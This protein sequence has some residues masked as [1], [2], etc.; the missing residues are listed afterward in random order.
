MWLCR[1]VK[2]EKDHVP[3]HTY[4]VNGRK[5]WGLDKTD[6]NLSAAERYMDGYE[7]N[8]SHTEILG[9][10]LLKQARRLPDV[11]EITGKNGA[12]PEDSA[13][14]AKWGM[15]GNF[16]REQGLPIGGPDRIT[17]CE[18]DRY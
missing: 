13:F 17:V 4:L 7:G 11:E 1:A 14:I 16:H 18:C 5:K 10:H 15:L 6:P 8:L 2:Q 12:L 3:A 9:Q